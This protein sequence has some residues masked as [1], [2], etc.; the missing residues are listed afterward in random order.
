MEQQYIDIFGL[1]YFKDKL[2]QTMEQILPDHTINNPIGNGMYESCIAFNSVPLDPSGI[3]PNIPQSVVSIDPKK[4]LLL[5]SAADG[6][7]Y[8]INNVGKHSIYRNSQISQMSLFLSDGI[9]FYCNTN[10]VVNGYITFQ[11]T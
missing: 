5:I 9:E 8:I 10:I 1:A 6:S 7:Y 3:L 11:H 4:T 2:Y